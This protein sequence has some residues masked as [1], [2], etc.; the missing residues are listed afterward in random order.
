[1]L[2][3]YFGST[4][5]NPEAGESRTSDTFFDWTVKADYTLETNA[6]HVQCT[7]GLKKH[8]EQLSGRHRHRQ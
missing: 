6:G 3:T 4:I 5:T 7:I 8:S 1:M 2:I